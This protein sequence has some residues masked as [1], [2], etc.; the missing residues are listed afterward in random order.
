MADNTEFTAVVDEFSEQFSVLQ[1]LVREGDNIP[2]LVDNQVWMV[3]QSA[4]KMRQMLEQLQALVFTSALVNSSLDLDQ[5][6]E[7]VIDVVVD[8]SGAERIYVMLND[9]NGE[10]AIRA[11]RNWDQE[12]LSEDDVVFSHNIVATAI[13]E[14]TPILTINAQE[15]DRFSGAESVAFHDLRSILCVPLYL[16]DVVIGV[17]YAD[18]R[19]TAGTFKQSL[20]PLMGAFANQVAIAIDN[21][22]H[23]GRVNAD[24]QSAKSEL[25]RLRI[26]LDDDR[27]AEEV[28]AI[29]DTDYF[30]HLAQ[31]ADDLRSRKSKDE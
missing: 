11:A 4:D 27:V 24:L 7:S 30:Q 19:M 14:R 26:K 18:N 17:L 2:P 6:L 20:V 28:T 22:R 25:Q 29:T 10:L 8:I 5:T 9:R 15:D 1:R 16:R 21:A 31:A 23:F 3:H 13:E 12:S